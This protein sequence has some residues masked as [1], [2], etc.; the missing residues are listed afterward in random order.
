MPVEAHECGPTGPAD[1]GT[2]AGGGLADA[3][4]QS[5]REGAGVQRRIVGLDLGVASDHTAVI[6]DQ[7]GAELGRRRVRPTGASLQALREQALAGAQ[8]TTV[9]EVVIEPT[10]PAWL[11]VAVY[12]PPLRCGLPGELAEGGRPAPLRSPPPQDQPHRRHHPGPHRHPGR[13]GAA[14]G[15]AATGCRRR[16]GPP[17]AGDRAADRGDR[18][19]QGPHP[20]PGPPVDADLGTG[21][22]GQDRARR[23][24]DPARLGR[25]QNPARGGQTPCAATA[26]WCPARRRR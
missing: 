4:D 7:T 20:R 17:G 15:R 18:R 16:A 26:R 24:R 12:S 8:T 9:V 21:V 1:P 6:V 14:P 22:L 19:P 5:Q 3:A 10:G 23:P 25:P 11:P 2:V 13:P